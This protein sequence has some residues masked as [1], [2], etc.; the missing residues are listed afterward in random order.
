MLVIYFAIEPIKLLKIKINFNYNGY[1]IIGQRALLFHS[2]RFTGLQAGQPSQLFQF[3]VSGGPYIL[4]HRIAI[5]V[6]FFIATFS[7]SS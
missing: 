7:F 1:W 6:V 5:N 3:A 4:V 2:H